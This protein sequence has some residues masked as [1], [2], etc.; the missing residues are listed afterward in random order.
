MRRDA[1]KCLRVSPQV[2]DDEIKE[3]LPPTRGECHPDENPDDPLTGGQ[4]LQGDQRRL[5]R[6]CASPS[7]VADATCSVLTAKAGRSPF[8]AS[9][10]GLN[11]LVFDAFQ[12]QR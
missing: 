11:N 12:L 2:T 10:V 4:A 3:A 1:S 7:G 9:Q 8:G 6:R 5:A